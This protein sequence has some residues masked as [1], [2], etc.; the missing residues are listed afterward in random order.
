VYR[1]LKRYDEAMAAYQQAI[2]L[3][4]DEAYC[5]SNL[6]STLRLL[7]RWA[8][9]EVAIRRSLAL[10]SED[11]TDWFV[12]ADL[13]RRRKDEQGW[14]EALAQAQPLVDYSDLYNAACYES[15]AGHLDRALELL[16]QAAAAGRFNP[17][18]AQ[19]D[20]ALHWVRHDPRFWELVKP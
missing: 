20:P 17:D 6:G 2:A 18:W 10:N 3:E 4:P 12:L 16:A 9:A 5:Q 8:E 11:W 13:L 14:Q 7:G 15:V 19:V 1:A